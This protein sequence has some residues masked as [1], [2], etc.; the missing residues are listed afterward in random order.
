MFNSWKERLLKGWSLMRF[1]RF[2]LSILVLIEAW[3]SRE[4]LFGLLG[5]TLLAQSLLNIGC[6]SSTGCDINQFPGKQKSQSV[7]PNEVIFEEV[8]DLKK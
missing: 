2:C 1:L 4:M 6:C 3:K 5:A 8:K 7:N